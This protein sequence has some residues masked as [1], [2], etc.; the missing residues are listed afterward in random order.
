MFLSSLL[1]PVIDA[2]EPVVMWLTVAIVCAAVLTGTILFFA[3]RD[4]FAKYVKFAVWGFVFYALVM[5]IFMLAANIA[6]HISDEYLTENWLNKDVIPYVFIPLLVAVIV[7]LISAAALFALSLKKVDKKIFKP[8]AIACGALCA[9]AVVAAAVT[10]A[11]YF[12]RHIVNDGYFDTDST[13]LNQVALYVSAGALIAA[14]I[15]CAFVL[16]RKDKKPFDTHCIA[17]AGICVAMSFALSYVKL[18]EMPQGGSITFASLLPVMLFAYVYGPKKGVMVGVVYGVLQAVQDP[19]IIHPAQFLLDYPI[20]FSMVGFAGVFGNIKALDKVPQVKFTLGAILAGILRFVCH[21]LSGVYAFG[22][23]AVDKGY[24][25]FWIYST[26]YNSFVFVDLV[27]VIV[28]GALLFTSKAFNKQI[29]RYGEIRTTA[30]VS[31]SVE[32]T[33]TDSETENN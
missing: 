5:G 11:I 24:S 6:K 14:V 28:A 12:V 4:I 16:G 33:A 26:A 9:A 30:D 10:M 8:V 17:L 18:F 23:Y 13:K 22:A 27:L 19:W 2:A 3:K 1:A 21:V 29:K 25:N 31:V 7:M 20:A 32:N 15:V